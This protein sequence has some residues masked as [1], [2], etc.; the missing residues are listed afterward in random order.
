VPASATTTRS[1]LEHPFY[2]R[3]QR[4]EL[5]REELAGYAEQYRHFEATLPGMLRSLIDRTAD[6]A[7]A[8]QLRRNLV[9]EESN[10]RAHV[11]LFAE[12]ANAVGARPQAPA[13]AA[14][15]CLLDVYAELVAS[16]VASGVAAIAAY[17]SQAPAVAESKAA[18]LRQHYGFDEAATAFWDVH[19]Q[20]DRDH[21]AW[22]D[23]TL[24]LIGADPHETDG[25][26]LRAMD[27]WW[28]FLDEREA[29]APSD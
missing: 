27:A 22:G 21:A 25:A 13:T 26:A 20:M 19:A 12:F 11:E 3:W 24:T 1:L 18:G 14:T 16:S 10:P 5:Q 28:A 29:A 23:E 8:G 4:G 7:V 2:V 9:D 17:E 6:P 15:R